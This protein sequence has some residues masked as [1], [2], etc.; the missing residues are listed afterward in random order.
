MS[1]LG[2]WTLVIILYQ[3]VLCVI[4]SW[5]VLGCNLM[6][7]AEE[8]HEVTLM[9]LLY[10]YDPAACGRMQ[11]FN[12]TMKTATN[13]H[14]ST[15]VWPQRNS[16]AASFRGKVRL[17]LALHLLWLVLA[18]VNLTQGHRTCGFYVGL[19]PFSC[20]GLA[21]SL[22]DVIFT[23]LFVRDIE[24]TSTEPKLS[25]IQDYLWAVDIL[26]YVQSG[27]GS[28]RWIIKAMR[29][30]VPPV[31]DKKHVEDTS[32]VAVMMAYISCRG[33][34]QWIVNLWLV[35]DNFVQGRQAY[36]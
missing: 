11:F 31:I 9:K 35:K 13:M 18:V 26:D 3:T 36:R 14:V 34:V 21:L 27:D 7:S 29:W 33:V 17:W 16:V 22:V 15:I 20:T 28:L 6:P 4:I 32:W 23:G 12:Y 5:V 8:L 1:P 25:N 2:V 30:R 24:R 10:L 19:L